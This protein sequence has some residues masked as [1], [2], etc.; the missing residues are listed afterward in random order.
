MMNKRRGT[1]LIEVI[2]SLFVIETVIVG[3]IFI[4]SVAFKTVMTIRDTLIAQNLSRE[5]VEVVRK[6][7]N[8]NLIRYSD[9]ACWNFE[10][11]ATDPLT[12]CRIQDFHLGGNGHNNY[13][14][15]FSEPA[16]GAPKDFKIDLVRSG[17]CALDLKTPATCDRNAD[18]Q[19]KLGEVNNGKFY[20]SDAAYTSTTKFHR[21]IKIT[22][23]YDVDAIKVK[24]M[25]VDSIVQWGSNDSAKEISMSET[26]YNNYQR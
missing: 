18:Y 2:V 21:M 11:T 23:E 20:T 17:V 9:A 8:S 4:V 10:P 26:F 7:I 15:N 14:L 16:A 22:P 6:V 5:G 25:K 12:N 19:L 24:K 1:T 3:S 13:I